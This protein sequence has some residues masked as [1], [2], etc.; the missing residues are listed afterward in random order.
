[1]I[2]S[3]MFRWAMMLVAAVYLAG[4][5][6]CVSSLPGAYYCVTDLRGD[7]HPCI[8][9]EDGKEKHLYRADASFYIMFLFWGIEGT[10]ITKQFFDKPVQSW[11]CWKGYAM[12][13]MPPQR[14]GHSIHTIAKGLSPWIKSGNNWQDPQPARWII[15]TSPFVVAI[16][17]DQVAFGEFA[18]SQ[19]WQPRFK[20]GTFYAMVSEDDLDHC[21]TELIVLD[22]W[23]TDLKDTG[24]EWSHKLEKTLSGLSRRISLEKPTTLREIVANHPW[25]SPP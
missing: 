22:H 20:L 9:I 21:A 19:A 7:P 24:T 10:S 13:N 14:N 17:S 2:V 6:G 4:L 18:A 23:P 1:M 12:P 25:E 11:Q 16:G 3:G 15:A 8:V 5:A